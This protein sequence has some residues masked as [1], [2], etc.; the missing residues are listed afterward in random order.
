[1]A[2]WRMSFGRW[3]AGGALAS[4]LL[5]SGCGGDAGVDLNGKVF[6]LMGISPAA[7]AAKNAEP[8]VAERA[9]LV[10]PPD[11]S[12]LPAP[13]SGEAPVA[14]VAWPD[15][16]DQRKRTAVQERERLHLAYCRGDIQWKE[17]VLDKDSVNTPRSPYGP[18]PTILGGISVNNAIGINENKDKE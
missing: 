4:A 7:Q 8:K 16:P 1:M 13:G 10:M 5:L 18:C 11:T 9:P 2:Q 3:V 6:D 15:D 14:Q 12:R 17:K